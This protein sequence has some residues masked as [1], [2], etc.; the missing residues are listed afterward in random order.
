MPALAEDPEAADV[1]AATTQNNVND[2]VQK[3]TIFPP[4]T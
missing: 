3:V 1:A 4:P 2:F